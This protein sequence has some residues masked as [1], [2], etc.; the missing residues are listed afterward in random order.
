M[1]ASS[2]CRATFHA[3][4]IRLVAALLALGGPIVLQGCTFGG[5]VPAEPPPKPLAASESIVRDLALG[6]S[7]AG[8]LDC[9]DGRCQIRYRLVVPSSGELVVTVDGPA[10]S[11]DQGDA[12]PRIARVVLEGVAQQP[13][14]TRVRSEGPPPFVVKSPVQGGVHSVL[15]QALGGVT[16]YRVSAAF[17]PETQ[18]V[19][20]ADTQLATPDPIPKRPKGWIAPVKQTVVPLPRQKSGDLSDGADYV[21]NPRFD[22]AN[23]RTYAF[24][25]DPAAMLQGKPGSIQGNV[26]VLREVQRYV[27]YALMDDGLEQVAIDEAQ[28]L[29]AIGVGKQ[30]T[31]WWSPVMPIMMQPY[32]YYYS[33]W[34][35]GGLAPQTYEDGTLLI[36]FV[37]PKSGDLLWHGW[38]VEPIGINDSQAAIIK[39]AVDKVLGQL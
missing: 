22:I 24:A 5:Y 36:D 3:P 2:K 31:L 11:G 7:D 6:A 4:R 30:S 29:I 17:T 26:F 10:G 35:L 34:G 14:A 8:D 1:H 23:V 13:V 38:A 15:I 37:D 9:P 39:S 28:F 12:G 27:R 18:A 32:G 25:Q 16:P 33:A 20:E 19:T 21:A